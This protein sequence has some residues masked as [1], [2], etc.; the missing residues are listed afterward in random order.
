MAILKG[1]KLSGLVGNV[2]ARAMGDGTQVI[3]SKGKNPKQTKATKQSANLFGKASRIAN[4]TRTNLAYCYNHYDKGMINRL[5]VDMRSILDNCYDE[6]T[7]TYTFAPDSFRRLVGFEFNEKSLLINSI[8]VQPQIR[9]ENDK[10]M[11]HMPEI[12]VPS[13]LKFPSRATHCQ[14]VFG[15]TLYSPETGRSWRRGYKTSEICNTSG[16]VPAEDL[17]LEIPAGVLCVVGL[18]LQYYSLYNS[19]R[20]VLN[21]K[22]FD[23]AGICAA[24]IHPGTFSEKD[25]GEQKIN[26]FQDAKKKLGRVLFSS[27]ATETQNKSRLNDAKLATNKLEAL[28]TF[29]SKTA[30]QKI[31]DV[32]R[33]L[34]KIGLA[35][36]DIANATGLSDEL[37]ENL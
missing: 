11:I 20:T 23:P 8:L 10:L 21:H 25:L 22:K 35:T 32:A 28:G 17:E 13:Q 24:L 16:T 4:S 34:K 6:E 7:T 26:W 14:P 36:V 33:N 15:V 37:I 5:T 27:A 9:I 29:Q 12:E 19:I 2:V 1:K 31:L 18:G 3:Q 30:D